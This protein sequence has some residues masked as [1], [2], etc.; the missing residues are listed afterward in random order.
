MEIKLL[1]NPLHVTVTADIKMAMNYQKMRG[2]MA[3][4]H[5]QGAMKMWSKLKK[6]SY[7]ISV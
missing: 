3:G 5:D 7:Q 6:L 1:K 4:Q 2:T